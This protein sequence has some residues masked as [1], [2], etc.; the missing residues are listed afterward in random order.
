MDKIYRAIAAGLIAALFSVG[1]VQAQ[2]YILSPN[3]AFGGSLRST[4]LLLVA[5]NGVTQN[6]SWPTSPSLFPVAT[7]LTNGISHPGSGMTVDGT[8]A[9]NVTLTSGSITSAI[10]TTTTANPAISGSPTSGFYSPGTNVIGIELNAIKAMQWNTLGSGVDYLTVTPGK[11][12]TVPLISVNGSTSNQGLKISST[13]T[14]PLTLNA[15]VVSSTGAVTTGVWNG[16]AIA[17]GYMALGSSTSA[18]AVQCDGSSIIC[19]GG[20]IS[21]VGSATSLSGLTAA[22]TGATLSNGTNAIVWGWATT[23]GNAFSI[24]SSALTTGKVVDIENTSGVNATGYAGYFK[25]ATTGAGFGLYGT[26]TGASNTGYGVYGQND[27]ATGYGVY[28]A[29]TSGYAGYFSGKANVTGNLT[30]AA[31]A[32]TGTLTASGALNATNTATVNHLIVSSECVGCGSG[33]ALVTTGTVS[34]QISA[35][36]TSTV[37]TST[38]RNYTIFFNKFSQTG[39]NTINVKLSTDNCSTYE[40]PTN[41]GFQMAHSSSLTGYSGT[42]I[43]LLGS[44]AI[45]QKAGGK[46]TL[47]NPSAAQTISYEYSMDGSDGTGGFISRGGGAGDSTS[48][49]NCIQIITAAGTMTFNYAVYGYN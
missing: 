44:T 43:D 49:V 25:N 32:F 17:S 29:S 34:A 38:Y 21:T 5:R 2:Q 23:T 8:G 30:G 36:I 12:G 28:G 3:I 45:I 39:G 31:A 35:T 18:G 20:V 24:T 7:S 40:N 37:F 15:L 14:G 42:G 16:T 6:V 10:G 22:T 27:S 47:F 9:L 46:F 33:L 13:G 4:D 48:A 19:S 26:A 11:S 41:V 1:I